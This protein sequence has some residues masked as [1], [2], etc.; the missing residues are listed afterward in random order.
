MTDTTSTIKQRMII[1]IKKHCMS[2][3]NFYEK[4]RVSNGI[5]GKK[6]GVSEDTIVKFLDFF[7]DVNPTWLM[8]GQEE[9]VDTIQSNQNHDQY[10]TVNVEVF[11]ELKN[12]LK[13]KD[14]QING[15]INKISN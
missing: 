3:N 12:Q 5:L 13:N 7:P 10:I 15:L 11:N 9:T 6:G 14:H 4:S 1:H 2:L 8:T